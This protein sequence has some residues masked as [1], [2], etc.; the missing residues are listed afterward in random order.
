MRHRKKNFW[1]IIFYVFFVLINRPNRIRKV[2]VSKHRPLYGW[3]Q[4]YSFPRYPSK[5]F[6]KFRWISFGCS[7]PLKFAKISEVTCNMVTSRRS[8]MVTTGFNKNDLRMELL[9]QVSLKIMIHTFCVF[10][11]VVCI[12]FAKILHTIHYMPARH[13][14][15][16]NRPTQSSSQNISYKFS[17]LCWPLRGQN[18]GVLLVLNNLK[19]SNTT[20]FLFEWVFQTLQGSFIELEGSKLD[21]VS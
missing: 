4:H 11:H 5:N 2:N 9:L 13:H 20:T 12:W 16:N 17:S 6:T 3:F 14:I 8:C 21:C 19:V 18:K 15:W 7:V 1:K 10:L